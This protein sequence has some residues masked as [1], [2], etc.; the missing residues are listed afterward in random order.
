[1]RMRVQ[2]M[3]I[4]GMEWNGAAAAAAA[5]GTVF[6]RRSCAPDWQPGELRHTNLFPISY[7]MSQEEEC[8]R[9][10]KSLTHSELAATRKLTSL[11]AHSLYR[12]DLAP[13]IVREWGQ[14]TSELSEDL[15]TAIFLPII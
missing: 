13:D 6:A 9:G 2:K 12:G 3:K 11:P 8:E 5:A 4:I 15:S 14:S 1:M 7:Q 10:R